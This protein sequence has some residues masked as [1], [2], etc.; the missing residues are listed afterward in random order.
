M[1]DRLLTP[2]QLDGLGLSMMTL[3]KELWV[4]RDRVAVLEKILENHG[5]SARDEIDAFVPD[6]EFEEALAQE[7]DK[8]ITSVLETLSSKTD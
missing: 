6:K 7:R 2:D 8:F 1:T 4:L 5:I 3:A